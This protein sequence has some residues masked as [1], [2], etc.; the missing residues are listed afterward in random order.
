MSKY[1]DI[2]LSN[3]D[4][5]RETIYSVY[6]FPFDQIEKYNVCRK[7]RKAYINQLLTFDIEST[8]IECEKPYGFMYAWQMCI[9][10]RVIFGRKWEEFIL[11]MQKIVDA[12][13]VTPANKIVIWVHNL[14]YEF[15]FIK[16]F[17][18]WDNVFSLA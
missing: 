10:N 9:E 15:Q 5:S 3:G 16:N 11:F 8:T 1:L 13:R 17:F 14:S 4:V 7:S 6:D 12:Q 2:H 18:Q